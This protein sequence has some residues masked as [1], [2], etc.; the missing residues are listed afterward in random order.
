[1]RHAPDTARPAAR[2]GLCA[3]VLLA[4]LHAVFS[5]G[6]T[7]L[8]ALDL[9]GCLRRTVTQASVQAC[10]MTPPA[11]L[12]GVGTDG[13]QDGDASQSCDASPYGPRQLADPVRP[14]AVS[15]DPSGSEPGV[16]ASALH[17]DGAPSPAGGT[18]PGRLVLR[19]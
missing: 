7:H 15:G 8:S 12:G 10:D 18:A 1:M 3:V 17:R 16:P 5:P 4:L 9:D 19:C 14:M 11:V 13:H 6:P 2:R